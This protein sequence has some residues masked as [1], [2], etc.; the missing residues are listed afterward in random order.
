MRFT[1]FYGKIL[2]SKEGEKMTVYESIQQLNELARLSQPLAQSAQMYQRLME[3]S[4]PVIQLKQ[5]LEQP[6]N[7]PLAQ[8][9]QMCQKLIEVQPTAQFT[10]LLRQVQQPAIQ[11]AQIIAQ[12][13]QPVIQFMQT[14]QH[15]VQTAS[16]LLQSLIN[17]ESRLAELDKKPNVVL[18][19]IILE[20]DESPIPAEK[21]AKLESVFSSIEEVIPYL[22]PEKQE[23]SREIIS[24]SVNKIN[25][26]KLNRN[27]I[28]C[29]LS[30][31][32]SIYFGLMS[33]IPD[34]HQEEIVKQNEVIIQQQAKIIDELQT[35]NQNSGLLEE[36]LEFLIEKYHQMENEIDILNEKAKNFDNE[37]SHE[38]NNSVSNSENSIQG[39]QVLQDNKNLQDSINPL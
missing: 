23:E 14:Y 21:S 32:I 38:I 35:I 33:I 28:Y 13:E 36:S 16:P 11:F 31:I 30:L 10:E 12:A 19:S 6:L 4:Q 22:E 3:V 5:L 15:I 25:E 7:Q 9:A 34:E 18:E 2:P 17:M 29:I 26:N 20:S 27:D 39:C 37:K 24:S 8:F 1:S